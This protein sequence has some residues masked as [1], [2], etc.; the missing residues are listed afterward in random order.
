MSIAHRL[1]KLVHTGAWFTTGFVVPASVVGYLLWVD[2]EE[3]T[4]WSGLSPLGHLPWIPVAFGIAALLV[5]G[6]RAMRGR[7]SVSQGKYCAA[8][9]IGGCPL[10][11]LAH[12][13]ASR[14]AGAEVPLLAASYAA[15]IV[16]ALGNLGD[17][18]S[19]L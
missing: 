1:E 16:L 13:T 19:E 8:G 3:G 15:I 11:L 12:E 17:V 5:L 2:H 14:L 10:L 4:N 18:A 6:V 7:Y 9:F